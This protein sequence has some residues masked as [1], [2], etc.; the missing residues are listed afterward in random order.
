MSGVDFR[1]L[2]HPVP[3]SAHPGVHPVG[4]LRRF[5]A[6]LPVFR[7][8]P[9]LTVAA[10]WPDLSEFNDPPYRS[11]WVDWDVLAQAYRAGLISGVAI[12]AGFGT[13]RADHSFARN[14][15]AGRARGI[16]LVY[17]WFNYPGY[18]T[19][20]AEAVIFNATVGPLGPGEAM[21]ADFENDPGA[22]GW[23]TGAA[24]LAW[25]REFLTLIEAPQNATWW[26]CSTSFV[27]PFGLASLADT[28]AW[29]EAEYGV[30]SPNTLGLS[31][32]GWQ[33]TSTATVPG[34][35]GPTDWNVLLRPP[36]TAWL[37]PGAPAPAPDPPPANLSG[38]GGV[39]ASQGTDREELWEVFI[40]DADH[41]VLLAWWEGGVGQKSTYTGPLTD[42]E[43]PPGTALP[44]WA[45]VA[46]TTHVAGFIRANV[47]VLTD[48][49]ESW[50]FVWG[51]EPGNT[52]WVVEGWTKAAHPS[53]LPRI[54]VP[55]G[56]T[57]PQGPPV[58]TSTLV[59][60]SALKSA[61]DGL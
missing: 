58:D 34:V 56:A 16:P 60:K 26:Y 9:A 8:H 7:A 20:A 5:R 18:N 44:V 46:V 33:E 28:W 4:L 53:N 61:I 24:A 31:P 37:T 50:T 57:G 21:M 29:V 51:N 11:S 3:A 47:D 36:F 1:P 23:P 10:A 55:K 12:R 22:I 14:Q 38:G 48:D 49:G 42:L 13:V 35:D 39:L 43:L 30:S 32:M 17:Y 6:E 27:G 41:H 40:R 54:Y 15:A 2:T 19:A 59:A 52:D 45:D 25:G